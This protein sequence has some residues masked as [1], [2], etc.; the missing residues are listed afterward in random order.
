M[1]TRKLRS[2]QILCLIIFAS[3]VYVLNPIASTFA[4]GSRS[5]LNRADSFSVSAVPGASAV[6]PNARYGESY[7]GKLEHL[8]VLILRGNRSERGEAHGYLAAG[9]IIATYTSVIDAVGGSQAWLQIV[10]SSTQMHI[11]VE[12]AD[13]ME[14]IIRGLTLAL[15]NPDQRVLQPLGREI[16]FNDLKAL[17]AMFDHNCSQFSAWGEYTPDGEPIVGRNLDLLPMFPSESYAL[18]ASQPSEKDRMATIDVTVFGLVGAGVLALNEEGVYLGLNNA[19]SSGSMP[20]NAVP[21]ILTFRTAIET[22]RAENAVEEI[23]NLLQSTPAGFPRVL[24]VA[25]PI[26]PSGKLPAVIEWDPAI[27]GFGTRIRYPDPQDL[28]D[29][30][31]VTNHFG[32]NS[33]GD[34]QNRYDSIKNTLLGFRS[35]DQEIGFSEALAML[36]E[37]AFNDGSMTTI[38]SGVVWPADARMMVS[39]SSGPGVSATSGPWVSV[40]WDQ[41]FEEVPSPSQVFSDVPPSHPY[42]EEIEALYRAGYTAGC[43]TDPL[44]FCPDQAMQRSQSSVFIVRAEHGVDADPQNPAQSTFADVALL[45]WHSRWVHQLW[46]D[47]FTSGCGTNPL[48]YCPNKG[49]TRA[50]ASVFGLRMKY[51]QDYLPPTAQGTFTDLSGDWWGTDWSEAAFVEGLIPACNQNQTLFCPNDLATRGLAAYM[52]VQAKGLLNPTP[53]PAMVFPNNNWESASPSSQSVDPDQLDS[54]MSYLASHSGSQGTS[55]ALVIRNGYLIW[56]GNNIDNQHNVWSLSKSFTS[57]VLGLLVDDDRLTLDTSVTD[58]MPELAAQ[59]PG[60]TYRHLTT[61]TSGYNASGG[62]QSSTPFDPIV[63][64]FSPG[65]KFQYW[66]SAMNQFAHALTVAAGE[67]IEAL[68]K[69]RIADPIHMNASRWEWGDWG[70]ID[71]VLVNGGAGNKSKGLNITA[72]ELARLGHL[73]LNHGNWDGQQLI[74]SGWVEQATSTQVAASVP[75]NS[76][77]DLGPGVYGF[78]WWV[79]GIGPDGKRLW[80]DAPPQTYL[81]SGFNNNRMWIIPEWDMVIV[82][83]GTD[84]SLLDHEEINVFLSLLVQAVAP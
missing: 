25:A 37:V 71:G 46:E 73:F 40:E 10:Q 20:A 48:V 28:P 62:D 79:N 34:S 30:L 51:G 8:P 72:R 56:A 57:S 15:P 83:L 14:G 68:F 18:I 7:L 58:A 3:S 22:A 61:M 54:A 19:G 82:R 26:Q 43:G 64:L 84:G 69:R 80:P 66:D 16:N 2:I 45:D 33:W 49:H 29:A 32:T 35:A 63:P 59:Y 36:D 24:H 78:N 74:S 4:S 5:N 55:Q 70:Q 44:V 6:V 42:A 12:Y 13:E 65:V 75:A 38:V 47:G 67:P 53:S 11:P 31:V 17:H 60:V 39:V 52:I 27:G 9:E 77:G 81:A 23:S 50:E 41:I 21:E 76:P 1:K